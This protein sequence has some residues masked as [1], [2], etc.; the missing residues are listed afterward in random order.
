MEEREEL[1]PIDLFCTHHQLDISFIHSLEE[2]GL[3]E[4]VRIEES[5]FIPESRITELEKFSRMHFDLD[6]NLEGIEAIT[7]LLQRLNQMQQE[8]KMLKNRL[9]LYVEN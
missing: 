9:N 2:Y 4:I 3:I 7:H 1:I 8:I 5:G 6:I